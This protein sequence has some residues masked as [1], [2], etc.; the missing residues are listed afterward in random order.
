[1]F[2]EWRQK[3]LAKRILKRLAKM[4][5]ERLKIRVWDDEDK[6]VNIPVDIGRGKV[7]VVL[8]DYDE[9]YF[10]GMYYLP[11]LKR[12]PVQYLA[13]KH[14][15]REQDIFMILADNYSIDIRFLPHYQ[16]IELYSEQTGGKELFIKNIGGVPLYVRANCGTLC[17]E[18]KQCKQI[19]KENVMNENICLSEN[20]WYPK[21]RV[22]E[23]KTECADTK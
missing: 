10:H 14:E 16:N 8:S 4:V 9:C 23:W 5:R 7:L 18:P 2:Q 1:M 17:I 21:S 6:E 15:G 12:K 3:K 19:V 13:G 11:Y 22:Y 20:N